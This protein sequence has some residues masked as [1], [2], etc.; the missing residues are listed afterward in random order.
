MR[1]RRDC[2]QIPLCSSNFCPSEL[3][4][5]LAPSPTQAIRERNCI[6]VIVLRNRKRFLNAEQLA[7]DGSNNGLAVEND[8]QGIADDLF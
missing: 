4:L 3:W 8:L 5:D 1:V 2:R 7:Y 6:L